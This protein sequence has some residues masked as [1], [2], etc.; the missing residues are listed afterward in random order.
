MSTNPFPG[1]TRSGPAPNPLTDPTLLREMMKAVVVEVLKGSGLDTLAKMLS[2]KQQKTLIGRIRA[3]AVQSLAKVAVGK[4]SVKSIVGQVLGKL[5]LS[6]DKP[7][8]KK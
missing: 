8:T 1:G 6:G 5:G 3:L 4:V 2:Q 7:A